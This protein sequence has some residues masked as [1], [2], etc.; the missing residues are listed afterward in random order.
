[1]QIL[2]TFFF[3]IEDN[4]FIQNINPVIIITSNADNDQD[5][6]ENKEDFHTSKNSPDR[7]IKISMD[8]SKPS[9]EVDEK[10]TVIPNQEE[11]NEKKTFSKVRNDLFKELVLHGGW[12]DS[13]VRKQIKP[14]PKGWQFISV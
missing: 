10:I 2:K 6:D 3:Q 5:L 1:M 4:P 7:N 12:F 9:S 13:D 14:I 8:Q 11:T